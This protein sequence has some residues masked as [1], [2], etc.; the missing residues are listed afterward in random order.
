MTDLQPAPSRLRAFCKDAPHC[1]PKGQFNGREQD[2]LAK[3]AMDPDNI[4]G[5]WFFS[6]RRLFL[7]G[8][9]NSPDSAIQQQVQYLSWVISAV[10]WT[11]FA[12]SWVIALLYQILRE[13]TQ[14]NS[15]LKNPLPLTEGK[16]ETASPVGDPIA[17]RS[18]PGQQSPN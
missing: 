10:G 7:N 2:E 9:S 5:V 14:L 8:L 4:R 15:S 18:P 6:G 13:L 1:V 17:D 12:L 11:I 3:H 16:A